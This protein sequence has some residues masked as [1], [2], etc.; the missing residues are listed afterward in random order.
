MSYYNHDKPIYDSDPVAYEKSFKY[1]KM[2][3]TFAIIGLI[4]SILFIPLWIM[5][6]GFI[7]GEL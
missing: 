1:L 4:V 5:Y 2:G 3:R 7:L 6:F